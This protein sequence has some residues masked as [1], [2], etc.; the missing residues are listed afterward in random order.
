MPLSVESPPFLN[1]VLLRAAGLDQLVGQGSSD[2]ATQS[3]LRIQVEPYHRLRNEFV[4]MRPESRSTRMP[5]VVAG[6]RV[7]QCSPPARSGRCP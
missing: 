5:W 7:S 6:R 4:G 1:R 3:E 2:E